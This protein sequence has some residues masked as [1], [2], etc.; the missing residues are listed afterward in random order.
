MQKLHTSICK[1]NDNACAR[2][3]AIA[4]SGV[5][6]GEGGRVASRL[7]CAN[8][9]KQGCARQGEVLA[10]CVRMRHAASG[11]AIS[12]PSWSD[13]AASGAEADPAS[14]TRCKLGCQNC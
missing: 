6:A 13:Q 3:R 5:D 1:F 4:A 7:A 9:H 12:T 8:I 11:C 2:A 10:E 14:P